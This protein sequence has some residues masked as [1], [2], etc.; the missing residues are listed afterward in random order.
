[1]RG[2][3]LVWIVAAIVVA[4]MGFA[5]LRYCDPSAK[6]LL[7]WAGTLVSTFAGAA[8]AFGF[9][10]LRLSKDRQESECVAGNLTLITLVELLE[11]LLQY[12]KTLYGAG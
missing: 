12:Q 9:N 10:A 1:M 8:I 3:S 11:R 6:N 7:P 2:S 5:E 4:A